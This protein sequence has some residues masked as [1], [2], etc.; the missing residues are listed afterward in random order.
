[1]YGYDTLSPF[2]WPDNSDQGFAVI[3]DAEIA[4]G[5]KSPA[6]G[7]VQVQA[8]GGAAVT[9]KWDTWPESHKG[10][11]MRFSTLLE[12]WELEKPLLLSRQTLSLSFSLV[13]LSATSTSFSR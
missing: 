6:S 2:L 7:N 11:V 8:S 1:M 4:S 10:L 5:G 13:W 12:P 3:N 9:V